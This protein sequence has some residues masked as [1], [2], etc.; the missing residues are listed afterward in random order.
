MISVITGDIVVNQ[1]DIYSLVACIGND[2]ICK[3]TLRGGVIITLIALPRKWKW[4]M[5]KKLWLD[6]INCFFGKSV[7]LDSL[8]IS[9]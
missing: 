6:Y 2:N 8:Q 1:V 5:I 9:D 4:K 7:T 3:S